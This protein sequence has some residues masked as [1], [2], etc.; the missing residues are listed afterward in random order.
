MDHKNPA[1]FERG[2][3]ESR[4]EIENARLGKTIIKTFCYGS[5]AG[6]FAAYTYLLYRMAFG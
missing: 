5:I 3:L 6:I 2:D 1:D 4:T